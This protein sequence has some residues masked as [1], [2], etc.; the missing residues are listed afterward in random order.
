MP[1]IDIDNY[2]EQSGMRKA[3]FGGYEPDDVRQAMRELCADYEQHLAAAAAEL[4]TVRQ[5]NDALRRHA[6]TLVM[7][8]Q[9]LSAQNATLAGQVDKLQSYRTNLETQYSTAKERNHSLTNQLD[10]LRLKNSDLVRENKELTEQCEEANSALRVKGRAH[11]QARQQVIADRDKV[12]AE[13]EGDAARIR[14]QARDDADKI[15]KDTNLKAE[16]IDQL[17]RE[18]AIAQARKMVQSATDETREIQN[19]HRLRLQDLKSRITEMEKTRGEMMDYLAKMIEELQKTQDY[20]SQSA[21]LVPHTEDL[22]EADAEPTLDLSAGYDGALSDSRTRPRAGETSS[23]NGAYDQTVSAGL[24]LEWTIFEGFRIRTD[25][26][27]LQELKAQGE[28]ETRIA[29]EDFVASLAAEYYN[30]VQQKIRLKNFRYAVSLSKERLRI[31]EARYRIGSFSRLDLLQARVDFN[32]DSSQYITQQELVFASR[33]RLNELM[34]VDSVDRHILVLDS[35]IRVDE[36]LDRRELEDQ[37]LRANSSLLRS[38]REQTLAELDLQTLRSRNYPY[39][40]LGAGYGYSLNRYGSGSTLQRRTLGPDAGLTLGMT[41]FDGNR[42]CEQRN[43]RIE[44]DNARL[45][46]EQLELSLEA[47]FSNFWQAYRNNLQLLNLERQNLVTA[48]DNHDIAMDR[49]IQ[50]DLSGFEVR[51]AQKSLLD[52]EERILSAQY[53]TKLCEISLLQISGGILHYLD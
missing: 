36:T 42:R 6:Q 18:Q 39:L 45:R 37:M 30:F 44:I 26:R 24:D 31:V 29:I 22:A 40:K 16:A 49:Y 21:P 35:L 2:I 34:A 28:L 14:Q 32:A 19:A 9:N 52:A 50:G 8:N 47:D 10:V 12:I 33:I 7:Q 51:E 46:T 4:R 41:I 1:K 53:N 23:E 38:A 25:Y 43:A 5:E 13:A 15:L 20:A 17:A 48:K 27:R 3:R 11:D